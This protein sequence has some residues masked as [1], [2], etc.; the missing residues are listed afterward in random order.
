MNLEVTT[1]PKSGVQLSILL[2]RYKQIKARLRKSLGGHSPVGVSPRGKVPDVRCAQLNFD[3]ILSHGI[4]VWAHQSSAV[5]KENGDLERRGFAVSCEAG[6][7]ARFQDHSGLHSQDCL[8]KYIHT[9]T[10]C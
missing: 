7:L 9:H 2:L 10:L 1:A 6:G 5:N 8:K 3:F 4:R